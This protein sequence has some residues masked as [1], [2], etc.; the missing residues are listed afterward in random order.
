MWPTARRG[1]SLPFSYV[2][3][4]FQ[5]IHGTLHNSLYKMGHI[6]HKLCL[7]I[8]TSLLHYLHLITKLCYF[9]SLNQ[10]A[11]EF[12]SLFTFHPFL[13][14]SFTP[15]L[16]L[17]TNLHHF[18]LYHCLLTTKICTI[19]IMGL[20]QSQEFLSFVLFD[21]HPPHIHHLFTSYTSMSL[22]YQIYQAETNFLVHLMILLTLALF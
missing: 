12:T 3:T 20:K 13:C 11:G 6:C 18:T 7:S 19:L 15:Y 8:H 16:R 10:F 9:F 1:V 2:F 14:S 21:S 22:S 4:S 5:I 17:L